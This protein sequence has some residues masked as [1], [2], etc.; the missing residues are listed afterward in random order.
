MLN[1]NIKEF[2]KIYKKYSTKTKEFPKCFRLGLKYKVSN[3][4]KFFYADIGYY[5]HRVHWKLWVSSRLVKQSKDEYYVPF[6]CKN[7]KIFVTPKG[8]KVLKPCVGRKVERIHI[9]SLYRADSDFKVLK[10]NDAE[11]FEYLDYRSPKGNCGISKGAFINMKLEDLLIYWWSKDKIGVQ[12]FTY[13]DNGVL[14]IGM[15]GYIRIG[16]HSQTFLRIN[17]NDKYQKTYK[18][19]NIW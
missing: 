6:P 5:R 18:N 9:N 12:G 1:F 16:N 3:S 13:K 10:P 15:D 14:E 11:V 8:T 2:G 7:A 17:P 19:K 4:Q